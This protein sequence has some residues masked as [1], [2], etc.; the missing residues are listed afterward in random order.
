MWNPYNESTVGSSLNVDTLVTSV[1]SVLILH[2]DFTKYPERAVY[3]S[4]HVRS[5][6][7]FNSG[8]LAKKLFRGAEIFVWGCYKIWGCFNPPK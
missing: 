1:N 5:L 3:D 8:V 7:I 6:C 4:M 2:W